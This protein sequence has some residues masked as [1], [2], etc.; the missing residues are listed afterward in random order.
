MRRKQFTVWKFSLNN[1]VRW[2]GDWRNR[3]ID[4]EAYLGCDCGLHCDIW[5]PVLQLC[6]IVVVGVNIFWMSTHCRLIVSAPIVDNSLL[7]RGYMDT[8]WG[9][10]PMVSL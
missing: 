3:I 2:G 7:N 9:N 5:L 4:T 1:S 8:G 10:Y 6:A